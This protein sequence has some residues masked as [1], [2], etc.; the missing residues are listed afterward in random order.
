M[1]VIIFILILLYLQFLPT[2]DYY[3][4]YRNKKHIL[5][6]YYDFYRERKYIVIYNEN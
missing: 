5:L 1:W 2:I 4:D 3:K 6:W